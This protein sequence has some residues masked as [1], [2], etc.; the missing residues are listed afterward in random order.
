MKN[1]G[2]V[3]SSILAFASSAKDKGLKFAYSA[4]DHV[5]KS[6][7]DAGKVY[8]CVLA[9]LLIPIIWGAISWVRIMFIEGVGITGS[10]D[11]VP[12]GAYIVG[13]VFFVGTSAGASLMGLMI[14]AFGRKD[15]EPLGTRAI[16]VGFLSLLAAVLFL[17]SDVGNPIRA[18]LL[19]LVLHNPTSMLV[20]TSMTYAG[21]AA[22]MLGELFFAVKIT[23]MGGEGSRLDETMAKLLAIG[24]LLFALM[25]VHAPHGALFAFLKAREMWNTPLLPPHFVAV[26]LASG[27]A[28]MIFIS[29]LTAKI[30][31]RELVTKETLSHMGG[32]LAF[33]LGIT[34]FMDFFDFLVMSYSGKPGGLEIWHFLTTRFKPL[35]LVN[36][37]GMFC[38][39]TILLFKRGR[40]ITGLLIASIITMISIIAYRIDLIVV[41]QIPPL[42]PGIGEIYYVPTLTEMGVV[43]G[44]VGLITFLYLVLTRV[45]PME[46]TIQGKLISDD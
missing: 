10:S 14:H 7:K 24:A 43:A 21:F 9:F 37:I 38:S 32:L 5:V 20:Y 13:F 44:V 2:R 8:L 33:F 3:Y 42:F 23:L 15:Y 17:V 19:P 6:M 18:G 1:A 46:E 11:L 22:L 25:V 39:M 29:I 45:L 16:I 4:K 28:L 31:K 12:W 27:I 40:H 41:A 34:L 30:T 35:F 36:T 26:A